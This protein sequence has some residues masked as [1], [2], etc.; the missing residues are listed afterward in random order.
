MEISFAIPHGR[1]RANWSNILQGFG[2]RTSGYGL[3]G[4]D[5]HGRS[6]RL[7]RQTNKLES[8][9]IPLSL[10]TQDRYREA[11]DISRVVI[12]GYVCGVVLPAKHDFS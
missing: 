2:P 8:A 7:V 10:V 1:R 11:A 4:F 3:V 9:L 5:L 12:L 6:R